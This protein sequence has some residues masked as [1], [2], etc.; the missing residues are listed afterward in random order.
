MGLADEIVD[1]AS[2]TAKNNASASNLTLS[3][4]DQLAVLS[5]VLDGFKQAGVDP[6]LVESA[7]ISAIAAQFPSMTPAI[8]STKQSLMLNYAR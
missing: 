5:Y 4:Q 6:N 1:R 8:E 7:K 2:S 3:V